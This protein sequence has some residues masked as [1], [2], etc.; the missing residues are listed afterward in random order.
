MPTDLPATNEILIK[1]FAFSFDTIEIKAGEEVTWVNEDG[2]P[3]TVTS[4]SGSELNSG[5]MSKG[6]SYSHV[7]NTPGT[8]A[9][10]CGFHP[11]MKAKVVVTE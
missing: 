9:Y 8:Y 5:S 1:G 11:A 10:H 3:H 4:D 6:V 7:F 2:A